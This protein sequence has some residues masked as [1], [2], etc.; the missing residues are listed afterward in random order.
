MVVEDRFGKRGELLLLGVGVVGRR[1]SVVTIGGGLVLRHVRAPSQTTIVAGRH[2][3]ALR[4]RASLVCLRPSHRAIDTL[5]ASGTAMP[6][7]V[8][9]AFSIW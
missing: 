8:A 6:I 1:K 4:N 5:T 9:V 3:D 2:S 7:A